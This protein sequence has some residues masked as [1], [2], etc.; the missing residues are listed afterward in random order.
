M[1]A[2]EI[3]RDRAEKAGLVCW[4]MFAFGHNYKRTLEA[5]LSR[6][7]ANLG[8]IRNQGYDE[9]FLRLWRLYFSACI[10]AFATERTSVM[11]VELR[12][13]NDIQG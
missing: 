11:Q 8:V 1:P 5:W 13:A 4:D 2:P 12:H 3:F 6:F 10:A 7:E 9:P